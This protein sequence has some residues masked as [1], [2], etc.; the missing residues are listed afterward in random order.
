LWVLRDVLGLRGTKYGCGIGYCAACTVLIDGAEHQ[1][2]PDSRRARCGDGGHHRR[3]RVG[4]D[5]TAI[6]YDTGTFKAPWI[7]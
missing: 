7:P 1:V 5:W 2:V 6:L 4:D 3:G